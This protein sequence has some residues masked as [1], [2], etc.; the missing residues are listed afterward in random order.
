MK[1]ANKIIVA[2]VVLSA[3]GIITAGSLVGWQ[4][5]SIASKAL[6]KR[7]FEQL[8]AIREIQ[9]TQIEEYF[10]TIQHEIVSLS[11][12]LMVSDMMQK[13]SK[14]FYKFDQET[15]LQETGQLQQYYTSQFDVRYKQQNP[16]LSQSSIDKLA[17]LNQN[18]RSIQHA[19][20]SGNQFELGSKNKLN[21]S[22][23]DTTYSK[24]HKKYHPHLN[25]Y[26]EAFGFYDIF[27]VDPNTGY[28]I[29]S[30]FK[31]LDFA[32]S[33]KD[34]P[35]KNSGLAK[36]FKKANQSTEPDHSFLIDFEPYYPSYHDA[37]AF[38][39]SPIFSDEGEK[40]GI[41]IFQMPIDKIN[42]LMT[43]G[44]Q[45]EK[46]G[47]GESGET[48][49]IG[50]DY[51]LRSQ[52]R[53]LYD[54]PQNY[55]KALLNSGVNNTIIEKIVA[56]GSAIGLQPVKSEG[57][58]SGIA[59]QT[60]IKT[61]KD[62]RGV[63]VLSAYG[64]LN[65]DGVK[66]AVLSEID[67]SEAMKDKDEM[68]NSIWFIMSGI[69]LVLIPLTLLAGFKVGKGISNPINQFIDQVN[70]ISKDKDLTAR[71]DYKGNDELFSL[72]NSFNHLL[73]EL[74]EILHCVENLSKTLLESTETMLVNMDETTNQTLH[75]SDNADSVA[76]ATNQ[77][78][79]TIQ[80]VARNATTAADTVKATDDK[81][82]ESTQS[83]QKLESDMNNLNSEM[84][85]ASHSI[86][87]LAIESE[88]IGSVLD[89]IQSIAEQTNLLALNAAIEAARAGEQGRGFAVVADEVRTLASRTQQS[90]EDIR[91]KINSLQQETQTTVK[92][93]TSSSKMANASIDACE[94]N[95]K[96][97][98]DV[99]DLVQQLNDMNLQIATAS[100][101][102]SAVVDDINKNV[103]EIAD[104]SHNISD[105]A[106]V[107]KD[108]VKRLSV[109]VSNLEMKM[110]EFRL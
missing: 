95:K 89:V 60:G 19:Y 109:L 28:V 102:Q 1:I 3:I 42:S 2:S 22:N 10:I 58:V 4:A 39:S 86:E 69:M 9:K 78:L 72:A 33:L 74:Q 85:N 70:H 6:E 13:M 27:L 81:C 94:D 18:T 43:Y 83:A 82:S 25:K 38:M 56:S 24:I 45:W 80:E 46:V 37:A 92:M 104:T 14:P 32:T 65:I 79:A 97:M 49:L 59:G 101:Q 90:T 29:Y 87:K 21:F 55:K 15:S 23:D 103:T 44:K 63:D 16:N 64:P 17:K 31:E 41:L 47:L 96:L 7:A 8:I 73:N 35:Y 54:D 75:Q 57:A 48:Y 76:V 91:S 62:Y 61:I 88:S 52:S 53:F 66:W 34:G 108:D 93:V 36:A 51:L 99:V 107:S 40:L 106:D 26:L 11:S 30:V 110:K 71:V 77:L 50:E 105:K 84:D 67:V 68:L 20:I 12:D 5:S 100:E 98:A